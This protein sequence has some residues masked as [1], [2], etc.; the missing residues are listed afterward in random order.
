[1]TFEKLCEVCTDAANEPVALRK[2]YREDGTA[3]TTLEEMEEG[4]KVYTTSVLGGAAAPFVD[5]KLYPGKMRRIYV[6]TGGPRQVIPL[7]LKE[8]P[9]DDAACAKAYMMLLDDITQRVGLRATQLWT[10]EDE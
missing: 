3:I 1:M 8:P 10:K 2:F 9:K 4:D 6:H 7:A 5:T